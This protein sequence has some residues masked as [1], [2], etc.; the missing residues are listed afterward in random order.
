[1]TEKHL[2]NCLLLHAHKDTDSLNLEGIAKEY[3]SVNGITLDHFCNT[4]FGNTFHANFLIESQLKRGCIFCWCTYVLPECLLTQWQKSASMRLASL[5]VVCLHTCK[6]KLFD[7][8]A[9][10]HICNWNA[11]NNTTH[12][13]L[14]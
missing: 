1:M 3:N 7:V 8:F 9:C 10:I 13:D 6:C 11:Y 4:W 12:M 5:V 14:D 2:N